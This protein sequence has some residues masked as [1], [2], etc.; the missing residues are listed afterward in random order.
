[1]QKSYHFK[2][3]SRSSHWDLELDRDNLLDSVEVGLNEIYLFQHE[4]SIS[5]GYVCAFRKRKA[6]G[7]SEALLV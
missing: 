1:M 5:L 3:M 4:A 6:L 7:H 2:L